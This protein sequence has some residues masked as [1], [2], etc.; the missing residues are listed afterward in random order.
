MKKNKQKNLAEHV[1]FTNLKSV[2]LLESE[3][4]YIQQAIFAK[5]AID[6]NN[7]RMVYEETVR[8]DVPVRH[9]KGRLIPTFNELNPHL[10]RS[11]R[12]LTLCTLLVATLVG[13]V[14]ASMARTSLPGDFL[15]PMK[16]GVNEKVG[17]LLAINSA[18]RAQYEGD[19]AITRLQEVEELAVLGKLDVPT[20]VEA[21]HQ[22]DSH[23]TQLNMFLKMASQE[24]KVAEA[25]EINQ[26]LKRKLQ[27]RQAAIRI[28]S[29]SKL[30]APGITA[31]TATSTFG[32]TN[33]DTSLLQTATIEGQL[34]ANARNHTS[35]SIA[36][37]T[38]EAKLQELAQRIGY[39]ITSNTDVSIPFVESEK[40]NASSTKNTPK[41]IHIKKLESTTSE[42]SATSTYFMEN[43]ATENKTAN[44]SAQAESTDTN[45]LRIIVESRD[46]SHITVPTVEVDPISQIRN[47]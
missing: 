44:V 17:S 26:D 8:K 42:A 40:I 38:T 18:G 6:T 16:I 9:N 25:T 19:L 29:T 1:L 12:T 47:K 31:L 21:T 35:Y 13:S 7:D 10:S 39:I 27:S 37:D 20:T 2:K 11:A 14:S 30:R 3:K 22:F 23:I 4:S 15:Y 28:A 46:V 45:A 32:V 36:D 34:D 41:K 33:Q 43:S 24:G 5:L